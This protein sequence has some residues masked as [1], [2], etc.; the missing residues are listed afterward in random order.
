MTPRDHDTADELAHRIGIALR[1]ARLAHGVGL[2]EC[3]RLAG[4]AVNTVRAIERGEPSATLRS[5][6]AVAL[7]AGTT[8]LRLMRDVTRSPRRTSRPRVQATAG[9]DDNRPSASSEATER[10][11]DVPNTSRH[12]RTGLAL[13]LLRSGDLSGTRDH[14]SDPDPDPKAPPYPPSCDPPS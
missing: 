5:V 2:R 4:V 9:P 12:E 13:R 6:H 11:Q 3:A 7:A 8:F 1:A 10:S 14:P